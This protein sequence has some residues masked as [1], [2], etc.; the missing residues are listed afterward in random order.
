MRRE[1]VDSHALRSVGYDRDTKTLELEFISGAVYR[2]FELSEFTY[3]ALMRAGS[4]GRF[5]VSSIDGR[6][7]CEEVK[8]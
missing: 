2:Y 4:K 1:P 8:G 6:Y 3:R 7:K 5:F